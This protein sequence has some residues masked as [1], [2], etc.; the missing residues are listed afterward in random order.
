VKDSEGGKLGDSSGRGKEQL[1][2]MYSL[3]HLG[4][5]NIP[6]I[7]NSLSRLEVDH[8]ALVSQP[9]I[10]QGHHGLSEGRILLSELCS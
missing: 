7:A 1:Q 5:C 10:Q 6:H 9:A 3:V 4:I 2:N 8:F